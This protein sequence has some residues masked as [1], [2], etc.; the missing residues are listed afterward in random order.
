MQRAAHSSDPY[1]GSHPDPER[2][3]FRFGWRFVQQVGADGRKRTVQ[4][5]LTLDDV[6]H[7]QEGDHIPENSEQEKDRRY[8]ADILEVRLAH[9]P[10]MLLLSDCLIDWG[11]P[12]V[13]NHSP[14]ISVFRGVRNLKGPWGTFYVAQEQARPVLT[15]EI[16]SPDA[17]DKR[18]RDNDVVHKVR[19]YYQA[20][21]PLYLV[22]DQERKGSPRQLIGYRRGARGYVRMRPN[23]EGRILVSP[24]RLLVG[25]EDERVVCWDADTGEKLVGMKALVEARDAEVQARRAAE[26]A[27]TEMQARLREL[28]EQMRRKGKKR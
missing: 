26:E 17:H 8:L 6:L 21:V 3:P 28:E 7:P 2:D 16:V 23:R 1:P 10:H 5:P 13:G 15:I 27:L 14:D 25:M 24:L 4:V 9:Q 18:A 12:G 20:G 19:E 22:V 11:V